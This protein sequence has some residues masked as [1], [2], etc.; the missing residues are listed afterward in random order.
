VRGRVRCGGNL[1][2]IDTF[3]KVCKPPHSRSLE[4]RNRKHPA[5]HTVQIAGA[6][7]GPVRSVAARAVLSPSSQSPRPRA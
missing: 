3:H 5:L 4:V 1:L 7:Y 2:A 6:C